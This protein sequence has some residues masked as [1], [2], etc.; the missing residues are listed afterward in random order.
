[1]RGAAP[2]AAQ[3]APPTVQEKLDLSVLQRI[4]DE[5]LNRSHVDAYERLE[6]PD[7]E[8]AATVVAWTVYEPANRDA[9]M[10]RG[11]RPSGGPFGF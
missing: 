7:L 6:I 5:G 8:Q 3:Q 9:M 1:M 10:P 4:R 2:V 11:P